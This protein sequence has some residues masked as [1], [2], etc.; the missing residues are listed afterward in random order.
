MKERPKQVGASFKGLEGYRTGATK[1][2]VLRRDYAVFECQCGNRFVCMV[3]SVT[4]GS[5]QSCG[6]VNTKRRSEMGKDPRSKT[7][8]GM[9]NSPE[10]SS[11]KMA[12]QRC[13]N[14]NATKYSNWGGRGVTMCDRWKNSFEAFFQDMGPRPPGTSLDRI[15]PF[16]NYEPGNCR[17]AD[18]KTQ[19]RNT[20]KRK[21]DAA[22]LL[23]TTSQ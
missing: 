18:S 13:F 6:C 10:W 21:E 22:A 15:D 14:P 12:K 16:G 23:S 19:G 20:R 4:N 9:H 1:R 2:V 5:T 7:K 17:W 3:K 11:W 8:H